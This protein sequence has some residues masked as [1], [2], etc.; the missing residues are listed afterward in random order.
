[1][2]LALQCCFGAKPPKQVR[3][4]LLEIDSIL[5]AINSTNSLYL[6][7]FHRLQSAPTRIPPLIPTT[8]PLDCQDRNS[9]SI[10][11]VKEGTVREIQV[12]WLVGSKAR[13]QWL[14]HL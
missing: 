4:I 13:N 6:L 8:N 7:V 1:M 3:W 10:Q 5:T 2:V 9:H 14:P 11:E 12:T